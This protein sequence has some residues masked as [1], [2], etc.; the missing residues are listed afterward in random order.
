MDDERSH[1]AQL[2][3]RQRDADAAQLKCLVA[4]ASKQ[5]FRRDLLTQIDQKRTWQQRMY[6]EFVHEKREIDR[7]AAQFYEEGV[8]ELLR[9]C[10]QKERYRADIAQMRDQKAEWQRRQQR[11]LDDEN[12]RIATFVAAKL[13]AEEQRQRALAM[14]SA[15]AT[16]L[17]ERLGRQLLEERVSLCACFGCF[18]VAVSRSSFGLASAILHFVGIE[19]GYA[20][21]RQ[22]VKHRQTF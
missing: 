8:Q 21:S 10:Q 2:V 16:S 22:H 20:V 18:W 12:E 1:Q 4:Q 7:I 14:K 3:Q 17:G 13:A 19:A 11:E 6:A 9:K 5:Q 15:S